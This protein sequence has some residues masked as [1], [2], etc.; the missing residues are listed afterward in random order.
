MLT[1]LQELKA[2]LIP[3]PQT[4]DANSYFKNVNTPQDWKNLG[5]ISD[6]PNS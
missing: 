1:L 3:Y 5:T 2:Q 6:Q 4:P